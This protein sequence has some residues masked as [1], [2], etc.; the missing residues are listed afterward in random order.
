[1]QKIV[2][3]CVEGVQLV[4]IAGPMDVFDAANR[5]AGKPHYRIV[6]TSLDGGQHRTSS[7]LE[8]T[9]RRAR[10]TR[11][12]DTL[13]VPGTFTAHNELTSPRFCAQA[14]RLASR[15]TRVVSIC[16]GAFTL[17]AAGL[18]RGKR[19]TAH[20]SDCGRLAAQNPEV[21]VEPNRIYTQDGHVFTSGGA[22][23]GVD[24]SLALVARD[25][26]V[27]TA[28]T[29]AKWLV[30]FLQRPGG[31]SQFSTVAAMP[32]SG[33]KPVDD[34]LSRIHEDPAGDHRVALLAKRVGVSRRHFARLFRVH[35][36]NTVARYVESIRL[37][38]AALLLESTTLGHDAIAQ[39][40][41][42]SSAELLRQAFR[43][44]RG[45]TPR[46]HR[47]RFS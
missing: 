1:M 15:A 40:S 25:L 3:L 46:E 37:S 33:F 8:M 23:A 47:E 36:G 22:T 24:L 27:K 10:D 30:V 13:I 32:E 35:T 38:R 31:Q 9:T 2:F 42:L 6:L 16:N 14:T 34:A 17:A 19:A 45:I 18:L 12:L 7:G 28:R 39:Q 44:E 20:W 11:S 4:D 26:G 29:V 43:R 21:T 5:V 41:G